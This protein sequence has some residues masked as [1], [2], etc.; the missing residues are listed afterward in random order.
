MWAQ[1][2]RSVHC[3]YRKIY[4]L[5]NCTFGIPP[6]MSCRE[7][8][9]VVVVAAATVRA[10]EFAAA[11]AEAVAATAFLIAVAKMSCSPA[12]WM[13]VRSPLEQLDWERLLRDL[14]LLLD[15]L[16][17]FFDFRDRDRE[18]SLELRFLV[19]E[20]SRER[21]KLRVDIA[22]WVAK[23]GCVL[24]ALVCAECAFTWLFTPPKPVTTV[25][26][27]RALAV[28]ALFNITTGTPRGC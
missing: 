8:G 9:V 19:R 3:E 26:S 6:R 13:G 14:L 1:N 10:G 12:I 27:R 15:L 18:R 2:T 7:F 21:E 25:N 16:D 28:M 11:I 24:G 4:A 23:N 22:R 5:T 17:R 20:R